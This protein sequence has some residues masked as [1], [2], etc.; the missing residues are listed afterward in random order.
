MGSKRLPGKVLLPL[1]EK[2]LLLRLIERIKAAEHIGVIVVA[3]TNEMADDPIEKLCL[4]E[5]INC[6]RGHPL[7]LLDRHYQAGLFYN[8][9]AVVKIPSDVPL[10]DPKIIDRV[11]NF[12]IDNYKKYD[13]I[14]NLHPA[15]YPD[16][17]DVE[18]INFT[19]LKKAWLM[20]KKPF[21]R[22]HTTPFLWERPDQFRLANI[23]WETGLNY[24]MSYRWTIDYP[25]DYLFIKTVY[26][27]LYCPHKNFSL[28]D[29]LNLIKE[30]TAIADINSAYAGV[31][32]YRNHLDDLITIKPSDT[33]ME[34]LVMKK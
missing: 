19:A 13:Y 24:A 5:D 6:F 26:D 32:W 4:E 11:L 17:N 21:E 34:P 8:A 7:D 3:T 16:G 27:H 15:S 30:K 14:S 10:I 1:I 22:E 29:I 33:M 20:A 2:P 28:E 18:V 31:N 23:E 25:A 9:D 12:Y